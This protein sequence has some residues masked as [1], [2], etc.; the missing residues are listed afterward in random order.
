MG[1]VNVMEAKGVL[2][3]RAVLVRDTR[4]YVH[5]VARRTDAIYV[6]LTVLSRQHLSPQGKKTDI[7]NKINK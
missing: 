4:P 7:D 6:A 2:F 3:D 5:Q 1:S